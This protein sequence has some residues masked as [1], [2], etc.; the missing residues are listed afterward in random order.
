M[1]KKIWITIFSILLFALLKISVEAR[2][3]IN[4]KQNIVLSS[5]TSN[6][7][8]SIDKTAGKIDSESASE[9]FY[10]TI[11]NNNSY[12][13]TYTV[14]P[15]S[16]KFSVSGEKSNVTLESGKAETVPVTISAKTGEVYTEV[17]DLANVNVNVLSPY[18]ISKDFELVIETFNYNLG[19]LVLEKLHKN[20]IRTDAPNFE[21]NVTTVESS[22]IYTMEDET[23]TSHYYRGVIDYNYVDFANK[24]W[25]IVRINGDGSY[26]LV[27]D[28]T[29]GT[30][31]FAKT[32]ETT[33]NNIGYMYS[34]ASTPNDNTYSSDIKDYLEDWYSSNIETSFDNYV[35]KDA[36]F[37]QDRTVNQTDSNGYYVYEGWIR[38]I[39]NTP[40]IKPPNTDEAEADMFSVTSTKGNGKLSKPIG[41]ITA[42][43]VVL[44]G[45]TMVGAGVGTWGTYYANEEYYLNLANTKP[46]GI[47]TMTPRRFSPKSP[48]NSHIILSK[49]QASIYSEPAYHAT[50]KRYVK[51]VINLKSTIM[52]KGSGTKTNPFV[53]KSIK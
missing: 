50:T 38:I 3:V 4:K 22:G 16:S 17:S 15:S 37:W 36:I 27:L 28:E 8:I 35:D 18:N 46:Y 39:N 26:R 14:S 49:P 7:E 44:A 25:R 30:S 23:D 34:S 33:Y 42:D 13:I 24:L 43:E 1:R 48:A 12:P 51:P 21:E 10:I 31:S 19:E 6:L 47:W 2:Y 41:L 32:S 40:S 20:K 11:K 53:V 29:A 45:A 9:E 52:V 5:A